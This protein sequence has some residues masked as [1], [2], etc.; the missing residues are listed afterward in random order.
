VIPLCCYTST[1]PHVAAARANVSVRGG[2]VHAKLRCAQEIVAKP[3]GRLWSTS[4]RRPWIGATTFNHD[5]VQGLV[6]SSSLE[7]RP[8]V[9]HQP[10]EGWHVDENVRAEQG[11]L[12]RRAQRRSSRISTGWRVWPAAAAAAEPMPARCSQAS[13]LDRIWTPLAVGGTAAARCTRCR[14]AGPHPPRV[15]GGSHGGRLSPSV[16]CNALSWHPTELS[17][18]RRPAPTSESAESDIAQTAI[19]AP[20]DRRRR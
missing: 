11:T 4:R 3:P 1:G 16:R 14:N 20:P 10:R 18:T 2:S 8:I 19:P 13:F 9:A 17:E 5:A 7:S 12:D 6:V 15:V